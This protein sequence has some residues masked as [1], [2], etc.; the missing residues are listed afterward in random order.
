MEDRKVYLTGK[1]DSE[2]ANKIIRKLLYF[3]SIGEEDI[4]LYIS[5]GGGE[6][7]AGLSIIDTISLLKSNVNT[8]V[9]DMAASMAAIILSV[10][11]KRYCHKN[12][13]VMIHNISGV[14]SR[15]HIIDSLDEDV[16][17]ILTKN[18]KKSKEILINA[19]AFDNYMNAQE[20]KDM[21]FIDYII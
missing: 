6:V 15:M 11:H 12:S 19:L 9:L 16:L 2:V 1:I 5:S 18:T 14:S 7:F 3:D 10:G 4:T 13:F 21:G 8:V 20:A 17:N